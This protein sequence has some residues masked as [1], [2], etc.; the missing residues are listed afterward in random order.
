MEGGREKKTERSLRQMCYHGE[1]F[2]VFT[3]NFVV[4]N[5]RFVT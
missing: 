5:S 2:L 1:S 3:D 4:T